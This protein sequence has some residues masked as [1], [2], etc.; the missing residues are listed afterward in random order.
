MT[1]VGEFRGIP[2]IGVIPNENVIDVEINA[3]AWV[4]AGERHH[5]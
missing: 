1:P 4:G 2:G 3:A 5:A